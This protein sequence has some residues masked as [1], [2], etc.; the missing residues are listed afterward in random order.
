MTKLLNRKGNEMT[1]LLNRILELHTFEAK[2]LYDDGEC[3]IR[4][5]EM[6]LPN[7][8]FLLIYDSDLLNYNFHFNSENCEFTLSTPCVKKILSEGGAQF[9]RGLK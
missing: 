4:E 8:R 7:Y 5:A 1:K 9:L 6:Q 3:V 2:T